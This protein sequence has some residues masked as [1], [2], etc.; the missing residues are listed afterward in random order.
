M[1]PVPPRDT[2]AVLA[3]R[4]EAAW[5][6]EVAGGKPSVQR[7]YWRVF[8]GRFLK[9]AM[10]HSLELANQVVQAWL[11]GRLVG[12]VSS[13]EPAGTIYGYAAGLTGSTMMGAM[14]LHHLAFMEGWRLGQVCSTATVGLIYRKG[15][16]VNPSAMAELSTGFIV[17]LATNDVERFQMWSIFVYFVVLAPLQL[18]FATWLVWQQVGASALIG[19][20][21]MLGLCPVYI[22]VGR[23]T[24]ELRVG[25]AKQTDSRVMKMAEVLRGMR[26]LKM[27]GWRE[28]F[29]ALISG[30][31]AAEV[32]LVRAA[33]YIRAANFTLYFVTPAVA[34]FLVMIC[35]SL[36][37]NTITEENVFATV[38]LFNAVK[39][40]I[41]QCLP[42]A[43]TSRAEM[44][45][46][47]GRVKR[48]LSLPNLVRRPALP[49]AAEG[50]A[51]VALD[52][53]VC[54][55]SADAQTPVLR[56]ISLTLAPGELLVVVGP[57]GC[58]K[59]SLLMAILD[60][61]PVASGALTVRGS[62]AYAPQEA[63][64]L[65]HER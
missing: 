32:V 22:K 1:L 10:F 42:T 48:L 18:A 3:D 8:R 38:G 35:Y 36:N 25:I 62:V 12:S 31:R 55:W 24:K 57:V 61:L 58:G 56:A 54:S 33:N 17:N 29:A 53:V 37:G 11:L 26:V 2:A 59:S 63:W 21:L 14:I 20:A 44:S 60:E 23:K 52:E 5:E 6:A 65:N 15:L 43:I 40:A 50:E 27:N 34:T 46:V 47:F 4:L 39:F 16:S 19:P 7:A 49:P 45:V 30:I 51:A 41:A 64:V 13:D 28:P 9:T